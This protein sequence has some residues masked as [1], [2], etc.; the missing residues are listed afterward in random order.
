MTESVKPFIGG[1]NS[2]SSKIPDSIKVKCERG[3]K[4]M[5]NKGNEPLIPEGV[6]PDTEFSE[7]SGTKIA[8]GKKF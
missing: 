6:I 5:P 7:T 8:P 1:S 4:I 2:S 3:P